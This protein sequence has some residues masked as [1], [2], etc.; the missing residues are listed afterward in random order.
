MG[1]DTPG[2]ATQLNDSLQRARIVA[3]TRLPDLR[4]AV[5]GLGN[6]PI[7]S[8]YPGGLGRF[9]KRKVPNR[10]G[11]EVTRLRRDSISALSNALQMSL[12]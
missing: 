10:A 6:G 5:F 7:R 8:N 1:N 3:A 9:G 11:A 12:A 2:K 4:D